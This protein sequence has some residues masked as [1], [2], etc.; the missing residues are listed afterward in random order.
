VY[1]LNCW[2]HRSNFLNSLLMFSITTESTKYLL[3]LSE[4]KIDACL[5]LLTMLALRTNGL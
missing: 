2:R 3:Y 5:Y 1:F 4:E